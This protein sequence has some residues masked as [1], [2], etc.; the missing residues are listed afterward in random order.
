LEGIILTNI[1]DDML[2]DVI[3][4]MPIFTPFYIKYNL[5]RLNKDRLYV[6]NE[7]TKQVY[8]NLIQLVI[9]IDIAPQGYSIEDFKLAVN[10]P[11]VINKITALHED[12]SVANFINDKIH[13]T[14]EIKITLESFKVKPAK[15]IKDMTFKDFTPYMVFEMKAYCPSYIFSYID[16]TQFYIHIEYV[17]PEVDKLRLY[18]MIFEFNLVFLP[19]R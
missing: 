18:N 3:T 10:S 1:T 14:E 11:I 13:N 15:N 2:K 16:N 4:D 5:D 7:T 9:P 8:D 17:F 12:E 6:V 19:A